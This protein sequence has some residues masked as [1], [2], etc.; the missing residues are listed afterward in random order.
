MRTILA[1]FLMALATQVSADKFTI[2]E[3]NELIGDYLLPLPMQL[4]SDLVSLDNPT[5]GE[6]KQLLADDLKATKHNLDLV[7]TKLKN[8]Y[9]T[10][11]AVFNKQ[12]QFTTQ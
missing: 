8:K 1:I 3:Y 4:T 11:D 9:R 7:W 2:N 6:E 12:K 5:C 10:H